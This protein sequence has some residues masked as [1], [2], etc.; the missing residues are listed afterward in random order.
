MMKQKKTK[1]INSI[2]Q[3]FVAIYLFIRTNAFIYI[4]IYIDI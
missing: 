4:I 2:N 1:C 3:A